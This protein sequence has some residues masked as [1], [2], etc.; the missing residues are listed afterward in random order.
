MSVAK[1]AVQHT[2][3]SWR[4]DPNDDDQRVRTSQGRCI[5]LITAGLADGE[6][7][8]NARLIAAAPDL[9]DSLTWAERQLR[10]LVT[11]DDGSGAFIRG[12]GTEL[13]GFG[14]GVEKMRAAI[15]KA[16]GRAL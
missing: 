12:T 8:A 15:A 16:E 4:V 7:D 5:A 9:L 6:R 13:A 1:T 3:G 10:A 11:E 14:A 2:P